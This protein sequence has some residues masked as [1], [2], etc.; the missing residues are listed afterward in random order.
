MLCCLS[1]VLEAGQGGAELKA[2]LGSGL[3]ETIADELFK[4]A[5]VQTAIHAML[6]MSQNQQLSLP[7]NFCQVIKRA[8]EASDA[9][10]NRKTMSPGPK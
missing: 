7:Q 9:V 2:C 4:P 10:R 6:G 8:R 1:S 3:F 5:L